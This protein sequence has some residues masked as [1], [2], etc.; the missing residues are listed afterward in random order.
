MKG[1]NEALETSIRKN[2]N[3]PALSDFKGET[4]SYG[5]VARRIAEM[6]LVFVAI[7]LKPGEKVA[8]CA[9]NSAA[10]ATAFLGAL[11]YGAVVVPLLHEF[12]PDTI[13][14][15]V[16]HS[17]ARLLFSEKAIYDKLDAEKMPGVDGVVLIP[18][19]TV[20][21]S[22]KHKL[23]AAIEGLKESFLKTY[24]KKFAPAQVEFARREPD[25][26]AL[27]NYT[28]GSTGNPKGVMLTF[29]NLWGNIGFALSKIPF[30]KPS[31]GMLSMLPL[32]HMYG[33]V[34]EFL[35]PFCRGCH[36]TFLGRIP[37]PAVVLQAF[38]QV[39][40]QL[41]ITVPL[42]IEKIVKGQ[43]FPTLDKPWM[44]MLRA[45]PGVRQIINM[46]VRKRLF[47]AF[48]GNLKQLILGGAAVSTDVERFLRSIKF[49]FTV[50]YGMT[51]CAP[52]VTYE[53]WKSQRPHSCGR[54]VDG[55]EAMVLSSD[56]AR[57]P[58]V[59]YVKGAN[60][61]KGYYKNES[62]TAE[63]IDD[64]GWL[65]TG[66]ICTID[67]DGYVYLRGRDKNMIL[68][69]SGQNVYPEEIE[70]VLNNMPLVGESV[71]VD[72][73]GRIVALVH[74]DYEAGKKLGLDEAHTDKYIE[75]LLPE[76]NKLLPGYS[77]VG[78]V[79]VRR[80]EFEKTPKQSIR[81]FLYK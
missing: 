39:K 2:W 30:L 7:G 44:K 53:W 21:L 75:K 57:V 60:V 66:D 35:F 48:G 80:E 32:A 64:D 76:L 73:D 41:V 52:L 3:L 18:D 68:T 42:V 36:I 69:S 33:L 55:M 47:E 11:T 74:P 78:V 79:E 13:E 61:M 26:L 19:F 70:A 23:T 22:R 46:G 31:D 14:N 20:A 67:N 37:S 25:A 40:P 9:K 6:H 1:L 63:A 16:E 27:I 15:L 10:W 12:H 4:M 38:A 58:G 50:G 49:P 71:V 59:L 62:A 24:G 5:H 51:E 77:Q 34:F 81:R 65:N 17:G 28:S 72:R 29:G 45:I 56:P 54:L 8:L 43:V